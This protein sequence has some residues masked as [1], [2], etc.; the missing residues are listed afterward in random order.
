MVP[1]MLTSVLCKAIGRMMNVKLLVYFDQK[2][3]LST[4]QCGG[5]AKW[6]TNDHLLSLEATVRKTQVKSENVGHLFFG[7]G[8]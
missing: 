6:T 4:L 1:C 2:G 7:H 8:L 3:I 5:R